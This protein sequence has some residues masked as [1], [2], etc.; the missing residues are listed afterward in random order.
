MTQAVQRTKVDANGRVLIPAAIRRALGLREGSELL[1][2]LEDDGRVVL[3]T[4][5]NAWARV[6]GMF[7]GS[8]RIARARISPLPEKR[9]RRIDH[10]G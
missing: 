4:P 1:V 7:D 2:T 9:L 10:A 5:A 3:V 6:Q 8:P